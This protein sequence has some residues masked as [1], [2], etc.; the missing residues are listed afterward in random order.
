MAVIEIEP[1]NLQQL[2]QGRK[3]GGYKQGDL[4]VESIEDI[5]QD[6]SIKVVFTPKV[7]VESWFG[8]PA[9]LDNLPGGGTG[10]TLIGE[11]SQSCLHQQNICI[12]G[13]SFH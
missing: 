10:K 8:Y 2:I 4:T 7:V 12:V 3:F 1:N 9:N 6:R 13:N 5:F 11:E